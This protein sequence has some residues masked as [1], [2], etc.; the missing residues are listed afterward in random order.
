MLPIASSDDD[1]VMECIPV[2]LEVVQ[3]SDARLRATYDT[4]FVYMH[5][6]EAATRN[7]IL[8]RNVYQCISRVG[9]IAPTFKV[10]NMTQD[11]VT[12]LIKALPCSDL[13]FDAVTGC[14]CIDKVVCVPSN[15]FTRSR[16]AGADD[17]SIREAL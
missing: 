16:S 12:R 9:G 4:K 15:F 2:S 8:E 7:S 14:I 17:V 1:D 13:R 10:L 5:L 3:V 11:Q 6:F